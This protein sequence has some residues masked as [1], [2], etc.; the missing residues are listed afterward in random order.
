MTISNENKEVFLA[1]AILGIIQIK[2]HNFLLISDIVKPAMILLKKHNIFEIRG[3]FL[4]PL[5]K[6]DKLCDKTLR[7]MARI[8][9]DL[10]NVTNF[11]SVLYL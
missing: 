5:S 9:L 7:D 1:S 6:M 8:I 11:F 2:T 4:I 3:I 10:R